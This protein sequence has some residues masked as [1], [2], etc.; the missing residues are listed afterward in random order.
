MNLLKVVAK[1]DW[2]ADRQV[3]LRIYRS[4]IRSKL[5]YGSFIYGSARKSYLRRLDTVQNQA[6]RICLGAYKTS[7]IDS[8]HVEANETPMHLRRQKLALQ[9]ALKIKSQPNNPVYDTIYLPNYEN[10]Y[11]RKPNT[12]PTQ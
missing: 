6:L 1:L 12:I 8:L 3:L 11:E 2:G 10:L 9:Y 4:L 5:D 7:P